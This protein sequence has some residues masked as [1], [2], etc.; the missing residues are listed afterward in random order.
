MPMPHKSKDRRGGHPERSSTIFNLNERSGMNVTT[1]RAFIKSA[2]IAAVA[3]PTAALAAP[4]ETPIQKLYREWR[5][6]SEFA[7]SA[8][9]H[10][11]TDE[12]LD[13][14]SD[15]ANEI[16]DAL[17]ALPAQTAGDVLAKIS[18]CTDDGYFALRGIPSAKGLQAEIHAFVGAAA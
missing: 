11:H 16:E 8:S 14:L 17:M 6:A 5:A 4:T 1:R 13:V 9:S 7:E 18:A 3:A 15:K 2:T 10:G 12:Q